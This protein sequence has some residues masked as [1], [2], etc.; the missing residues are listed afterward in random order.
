MRFMVLL[1]L[2]VWIGG[3]R[4]DGTGQTQTAIVT[5]DASASNV[6]TT[7]SN[8]FDASI[9]SD[10]DS[11][12]DAVDMSDT[13]GPPSAMFER[14]DQDGVCGPDSR[15]VGRDCTEGADALG[16]CTLPERSSCGCGVL[17]QDCE[18]AGTT[19]LAA[20][21][22]HEGLCVTPEEMRVICAAP[23]EEWGCFVCP[24][25][26]GT[27]CTDPPEPECATPTAVRRYNQ[28]WLG[29]AAGAC[30]FAFDTEPC[31]RGQV[32]EGGACVTE[33]ML[34]ETAV[35]C[36]QDADCGSEGQCVADHC[37]PR[38][39][40]CEGAADCPEDEQTC[41]PEGR[42]VQ[43]ARCGCVSD[44]DCSEDAVCITTDLRCGDC[45]ERSTLCTGADE[46]C[47]S[48][49]LRGLWFYPSPLVGEGT[50]EWQGQITGVEEEAFTLTD[51]EG[52]TTRFELVMPG[53]PTDE[54]PFR[55]APFVYQPPSGA[56]ARV[57]H[58][59]APADEGLPMGGAWT[60]L[61]VDGELAFGAAALLPL[62]SEHQSGSRVVVEEAGCTFGDLGQCIQT[63]WAP[64]V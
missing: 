38:G 52:N 35:C 53:V 46:R 6:A 4:E 15:C 34:D 37:W 62:P 18:T 7:A 33:T 32:C 47:G 57:I 63:R 42:C 31:P 13:D 36:G 51:T 23:E 39:S 56:M 44:A 19:C 60:V 21:C 16:L 24:W 64:L 10:V 40:P 8:R 59:R 22:D 49:P 61:Y 3:C 11:S 5:E 29:C 45:I 55:E 25:C 20:G 2:L 50:F 27:L 12:E 54:P 9:G 26:E 30:M 28:Q 58:T 48:Q 14:C 41:G 17:W 1:G 43:R